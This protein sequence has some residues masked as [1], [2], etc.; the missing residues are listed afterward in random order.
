MLG[1][2]HGLTLYIFSLNLNAATVEGNGQTM[3]H[4]KEI[5]LFPAEVPVKKLPQICL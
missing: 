2:M 1:S 4:G 5:E 3:V